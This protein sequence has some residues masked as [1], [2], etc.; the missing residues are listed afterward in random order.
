MEISFFDSEDVPVP[1][2]ETRI[3][4]LDAELWF[5]GIRVTNEAHSSH[6]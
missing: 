5:D 4:A 6:L 2:E 1:P 3:L